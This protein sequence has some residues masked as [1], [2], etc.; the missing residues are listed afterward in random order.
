MGY[1]MFPKDHHRRQD[2]TRRA[3]LHEDKI[4]GFS[5]LCSKHFTDD[6]FGGGHLGPKTGKIYKSRQ[7][8]SSAIPTKFIRE[9]NGEE[10]VWLVGKPSEGMPISSPFVS[11]GDNS[12]TPPAAGRTLDGKV[13]MEKENSEVEQ[14]SYM[15]I[16]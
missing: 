12:T 5:V 11:G 13:S 3:G 6:Q 14:M 1:H 2:W 9:N 16:V 7:L 10:C 8:I 4:H 15:I